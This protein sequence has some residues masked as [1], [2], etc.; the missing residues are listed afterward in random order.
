MLKV[1]SI[2]CGVP[3]GSVL[4]PLL[5]I[6]MVNDLPTVTNSVNTFLYVD[7]TAIKQK[8]QNLHQYKEDLS[9]KEIG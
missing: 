6:L 3:Q 2:Y 1:K 7:V 9:K 4:G 5:F 8:E